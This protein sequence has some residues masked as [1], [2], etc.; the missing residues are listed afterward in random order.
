VDPNARVPFDLDGSGVVRKWGWIT[1]K[2]A[3]LVFD[4]EGRG[5]I[6]SALQMFGNVTFWIFWRDGYAALSALDD[7]GDGVLRGPELR[8]LALWRDRNGNGVSEPGEVLSVEAC[9]IGAI[10]CTSE[11]HSTGINWNPVGVTF[12]DGSSTAS[13]DWIA[14]SSTTP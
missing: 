13:Y 1:P 5:K 4:P 11:I 3:W 2:A 10:S 8:G 14:A 6:T 9:G 7:D 12:T